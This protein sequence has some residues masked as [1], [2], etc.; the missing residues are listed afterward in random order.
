MADPVEVC[1]PY[2]SMAFALLFL[3]VPHYQGLKPKRVRRTAT[4]ILMGLA[5]SRER[6]AVDAS[7]RALA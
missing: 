5:P 4:D 3:L 1:A 6:S 7:M 2:A